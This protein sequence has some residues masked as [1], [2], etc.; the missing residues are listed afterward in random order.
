MTVR[1]P[2]SPEMSIMKT[3]VGQKLSALQKHCMK[4]FDKSVRHQSG[5]KFLQEFFFD[6][7]LEV[8]AFAL[9]HGNKITGLT[10]NELMQSLIG[11]SQAFEVC[12]N[13]FMK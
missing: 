12:R 7:S 6:L 10:Y 11:P 2:L 3:K 1:E 13:K 5:N 9:D 4:I 8:T